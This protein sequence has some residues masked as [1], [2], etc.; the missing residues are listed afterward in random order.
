MK[1]LNI[2]TSNFEY[3]GVTVVLL[4]YY[5]NI[6]NSDIRLDYVV[7]NKVENDLKK[8]ITRSFIK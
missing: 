2:S 6:N 3:T 4:S 8:K 5:E 1:I 7:P